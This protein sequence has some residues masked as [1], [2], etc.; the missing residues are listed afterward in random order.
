[1]LVGAHDGAVDHQ[2]FQIGIL[3]EHCRKVAQGTVRTCITGD[4]YHTIPVCVAS[5]G[6]LARPV[7]IHSC[8]GM[9]RGARKR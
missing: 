8:I 5:S 9:N 2:P 7:R 4:A 6:L 3:R 1:M